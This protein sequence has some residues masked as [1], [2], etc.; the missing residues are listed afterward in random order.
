[1]QKKKR[2][3]QEKEMKRKRLLRKKRVRS[4]EGEVL[5]VLILCLPSA[6]SLF[7]LL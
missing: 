6:G 5:S 2:G 1:M 7:R 3:G 4:S